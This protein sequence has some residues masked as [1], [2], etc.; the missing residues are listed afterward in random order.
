M[1]DILISD[2]SLQSTSSPTIARDFLLSGGVLQ[3]TSQAC[4]IDTSPPL[5]AG[6]QSLSI[7]PL[8]V[9]RASWAAAS[10]PTLPIRYETYIQAYSEAGLFNSSNIVA[11][12]DKLLVDIF[13]TPDGA[14][15]QSGITYH[16]GVRALDGV[17]NRDSNLV[18]LTT[19]TP[20]ISAAE[21]N[22]EVHGAFSIDTQNRMRGT[23]WGLKNGV[24]MSGA[25]LGQAHYTVYTKDGAQLDGM[26]ESSL[27]AD[28]NGVFQI[29]PIASAMALSL[30][31][32]I[33]RVQIVMDSA[34]RT[35]NVAIVEIAPVYELHGVFSLDSDNKMQATFW[36]TAN[37][38]QIPFGARLGTASYQVYDKAGAVVSGMSATGIAADANGYY[39]ITP[40]ASQLVA[41]LAHYVVKVTATVDNI[42]RT[43]TLP[44]MGKVPTYA[45]KAA[46]SI[47]TSNQLLGTIWALRDSG[48]I[49]G[50][51]LGAASYTIYDRAGAEVGMSESGVT[52]DIN[53]QFK[54][55]PIT[56]LLT[57][58]LNHYMVKVSI[59]VDSVSRSDYISIIEPAPEYGVHGVCSLDTTNNFQATFWATANDEQ[60]TGGRLGAASYQVYDKAGVA[61]T[62]MTGTG[63]VADG[64][65]YFKITP[66][67]SL[68]V[69]DLAHYVVKV[70]IVVDNIGRTST[71]AIAG[72]VPTYDL[73]GAF[74]LNSSNQLRG[75]MWAL[76]DCGLVAGAAL[77][78]ASY[79]I[80]DRSGATVAMSESGIAADSNGQFKI[81][82]VA[83]VLDQNLNHYLLKVTI[84]VDGAAR[85]NYLSII[86]RIPLFDIEGVFS[87]NSSSH[88]VGSLWG[89]ADGQAISDVARLGTASYQIYDDSGVAVLG[90]TQSG[91]SANAQGTYII[92]PI[93]S[94]MCPIFAHYTATITMTI[95]GI[96]RTKVIPIAGKYPS[97]EAK[98]IFSIS[99]SNALQATFWATVDGVTPHISS[100][101][102]ARYQVYDVNNNPVSGLNQSGMTADS[103]GR[104][105]ATPASATVLTDLTHYTVLV[106]IVV[107]GFERVSYRGFT[108]L[109]N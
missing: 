53:G 16:I 8:G 82:P 15:V 45:I 93:D 3:S 64:N 76:R 4:L 12:T 101:G 36:A 50:S 73:R 49:T 5:F 68:L 56:S 46:F 38:D 72:Y 106:G 29:T 75:T 13:A 2:L 24:L 9:I 37:D 86:E 95:D 69:T 107:N 81:T 78:T 67:A 43:N 84:T 18:S 10:D 61:V 88:L 74:S 11:I 23:L 85:T 65:G 14:F 32:Y 109:G 17:S 60:V 63:I 48:L 52:A 31:H 6:I 41:D 66:V 25:H 7:L 98:A 42:N 57:Q 33:V 27:V 40:V 96:T 47:N 94:M 104:Y 87:T 77:G 21:A 79:Q 91:I 108:L 28:A 30:D 89:M 26:T 62:G 35:G 1:S 58:T 34:L 97:F 54:I 59:I 20:G 83:S 105:T 44:I 90:M 55:S 100:L 99:A 70:T 92:T 71:V 103:L 19:T 102:V 22:Y 80:Y 51:S 39:K